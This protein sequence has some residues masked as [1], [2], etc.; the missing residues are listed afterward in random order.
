MVSKH[1]PQ[2]KGSGFS[3]V[4][5]ILFAIGV[6]CVI[7]AYAGIKVFLGL[8]DQMETS[9]DDAEGMEAL[10]AVIETLFLFSAIGVESLVMAIVVGVVGIILIIV[11]IST[12]SVGFR[13]YYGGN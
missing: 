2:S 3:I 9:G 13:K 1:P 8:R 12:W 4:G 5:G 10:G 11:G 6:I 7:Y